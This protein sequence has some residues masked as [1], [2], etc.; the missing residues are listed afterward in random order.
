MRRK[1]IV[2]GAAALA[3]VA[4]A[5]MMATSVFGGGAERRTGY[6]VVKIDTQQ[7]AA[8]ESQRAKTKK[9]TVVYLDGA[10]TVADSAV[11]GPFIDVRVGPCPQ[12][13]RVIEGGISTENVD[14]YVQ[15]TY[16][17]ENRHDYHVRFADVGEP[18][19]FE[20]TSH[21]TCLKAKSQG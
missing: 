11:L 14:V 2:A 18:G 6:A 10:P 17:D 19:P 9:P 3:A 13:T 21:L 1:W 8:A 7:P 15:G 16:I 5:A 12:N 20:L 4:G